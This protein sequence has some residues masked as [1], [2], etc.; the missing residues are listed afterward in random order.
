[1]SFQHLANKEPNTLRYANDP[2]EQESVY[3]L[4]VRRHCAPLAVDVILE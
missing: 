4:R 1:M 2:D 3:S